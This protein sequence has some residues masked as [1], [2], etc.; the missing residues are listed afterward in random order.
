MVLKCA[1]KNRNA[2][3]I[4]QIIKILWTSHKGLVKRNDSNNYEEMSQYRY[5]FHKNLYAN[6]EIL[7]LKS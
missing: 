2:L 1:G 5:I 7:C 4:K 6:S 3:I